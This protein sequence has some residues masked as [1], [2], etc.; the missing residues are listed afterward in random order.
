[1]EFNNINTGSTTWAQAATAINENFSKASLEFEKLKNSTT[2]NKGFFDSISELQSYVASPVTG[3]FAYVGSSSTP[4]IY[5]Y[6]GTSWVPTETIG[7]T[8]IFESTSDNTNYPE[9]P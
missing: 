5:R 3:D 6:D 7:G 2:R 9:I 1:M 8:P 4:T